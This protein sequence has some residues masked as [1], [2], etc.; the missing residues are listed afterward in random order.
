VSVTAGGVRTQGRL[1]GRIGPLVALFV[2]A[3]ALRPQ[4]NAIGPLTPLIEVD[5]D[6]SHAAIGLLSTI[7]VACMAAFS[8]SAGSFQRRLGSRYAIAACLGVVA[9]FGIARVVVSDVTAILLLTVPLGAAL[10]IGGALLPGAVKDLFSDRPAFVTGVYASGLQVGAGVGSAIA[11]PIAAAWGGWRAALAVISVAT[12]LVLA[13]WLSRTRQSGTTVRAPG[14]LA[15][16][17]FRRPVAW[18]IAAAFG[19]QSIIHYGTVAWLPAAYVER[20]WT[21]ESAGILVALL[22]L[23]GLPATLLVPWFAERIGSRRLYMGGGAA[24]MFVGLVGVA[25]MPAATWVWILMVAIGGGAVFPIV[26]TLP[27]DFADRTA[28]VAAVAA[29]ML[30][31][32]YIL[33]SIGPVLL[34]VARDATGSFALS[35]WL[36]AGVA[37]LLMVASALLSPRVVSRGLARETV[38]PSKATG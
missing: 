27:I 35:L 32:G 9:V 20:G 28:D 7:P 24:L 36:L 23:G 16:P 26:L 4:I 31:G 10:G 37:G 22:N 18:L 12:T 5:L 14:L 38:D 33:S 13:F 25:A 30:G 34:G 2:A 21:A 8:L 29:L 1:T 17:P 6:A 19:L 3:L 15:R 11:V